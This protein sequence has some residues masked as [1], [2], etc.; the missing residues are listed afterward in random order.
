[1]PVGC[2]DKQLDPMVPEIDNGEAAVLQR[3]RDEP[4][5]HSPHLAPPRDSLFCIEAPPVPIAREQV[6]RGDRLPRRAL[7]LQRGVEVALRAVPLAPAS[8]S[9]P[10]GASA[11]AHPFGTI[12]AAELSH[13]S[14]MVAG[15]DLEPDAVGE[16]DDALRAA[17]VP[18][19]PGPTLQRRT[20]R[21]LLR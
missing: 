7:S 15:L 6:I 17:C 16:R 5:H 14:A 1:M 21:R 13:G 20:V 2:P 12:S 10:P 8:R 9:D 19:L 18:L 4:D 11:R 3:H